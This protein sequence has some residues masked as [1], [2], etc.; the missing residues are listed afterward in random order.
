M[1]RYPEWRAFEKLLESSAEIREDVAKKYPAE[2]V[3]W[4][5][6]RKRNG[7]FCPMSRG[8]LK[9]ICYQESRNKAFKESLEKEKWTM[10][11]LTN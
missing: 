7:R 3:K 1:G 2:M 8:V 6:L 10:G 5:V 9:L 11:A 4:S